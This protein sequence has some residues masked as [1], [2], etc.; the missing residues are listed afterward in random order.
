MICIFKELCPGLW[1]VNKSKHINKITN[2]FIKLITE[3]CIQVYRSYQNMDIPHWSIK[4]LI[5]YNSSYWFL[6]GDND[7]TKQMDIFWTDPVV[8]QLCKQESAVAVK[9]MANRYNCSFP[10]IMKHSLM[11]NE[12]NGGGDVIIWKTKYF[13]LS[14]NL[15]SVRDY[16]LNS[17]V[18]P[19]KHIISLSMNTL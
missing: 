8:A 16:V 4:C 15:Y 17:V 14:L 2:I 1:K 9:I 13:H 5:L 6:L 18:F 11:W 12:I 19:L 7:D 3:V 10:K